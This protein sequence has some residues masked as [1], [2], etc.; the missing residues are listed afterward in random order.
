MLVVL[1]GACAL[2]LGVVSPSEALDLYS[3]HGTVSDASGVPLQGI[4]IRN[5]GQGTTTDAA[6]EYRLGQLLPGTYTL[7]VSSPCHNTE[8]KTVTVIIPQDTRVDFVL[9]ERW[10]NACSGADG[11]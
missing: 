9:T 7:Y 3:L 2:S 6:G 5:G 11:P 8:Q 4:S 10:P 1:L